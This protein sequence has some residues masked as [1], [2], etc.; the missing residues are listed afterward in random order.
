MSTAEDALIADAVDENQDALSQL[1]APG[2]L[3]VHTSLRGKIDLRW[4][5]VLS[6]DDIIHESFVDAFLSIHSFRP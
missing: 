1:L 2:S 5:S 3:D 4:R 6:D